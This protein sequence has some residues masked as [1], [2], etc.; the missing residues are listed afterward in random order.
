MTG[1]SFAKE[2]RLVDCGSNQLPQHR[3]WQLGKEMKEAG[4]LVSS[5]RP[6]RD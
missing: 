6:A 3:P 4:G 1:H 5:Y 2:N